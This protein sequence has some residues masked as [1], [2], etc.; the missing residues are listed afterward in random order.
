MANISNRGDKIVEQ[1]NA[2]RYHFT[3]DV[4]TDK[5]FKDSL[6]TICCCKT[7]CKMLQEKRGSTDR[8]SIPD[9]C[10]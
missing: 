2:V 5:I 10:G 8:G 6:K 7:K 9:V 3:N 4:Y 1:L